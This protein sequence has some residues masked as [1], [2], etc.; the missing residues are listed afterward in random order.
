MKY[1]TGKYVTGRS[2]A[3][4][5]GPNNTKHVVWAINKYFISFFLLFF[6]Y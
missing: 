2:V 4:K 5:M 1:A 6:I 3:M